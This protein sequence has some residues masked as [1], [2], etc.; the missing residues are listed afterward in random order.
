MEQLVIHGGNPLRGRVKIGGAKNAV[1]PIIAAALLGSRGV[2][3]LDDV[4]ALEDVYTISSVLRSL[5]VKAD[6]S[7]AEHRLRIDASEI[8]TVSA[9]YELV[10]KMRASF[11]IMGP[12]LARE[13]RAEI[14]LPGGCAI[15]T[16][17]I[18]L[19]LKGFEALG[20]QIDITQGAI[21]A[22]AP[23]G[24]KGARIYFDFP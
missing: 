5:G 12:L 11:L 18:D 10:R 22:S 21:H 14:S 8:K 19:H 4:P 6:Y 15:G 23:K 16:R 3:V 13:G 1:L 2:S 17:P 20:A 7:A 24:L 9:P